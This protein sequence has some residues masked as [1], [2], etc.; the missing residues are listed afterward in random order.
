MN[1]SKL[2]VTTIVSGSF[3]FGPPAAELVLEHKESHNVA[4]LPRD[5]NDHPLDESRPS[6]TQILNIAMSSTASNISTVRLPQGN[7]TIAS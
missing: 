1:C 7:W 6:H 3:F 2:F 5:F 4:A